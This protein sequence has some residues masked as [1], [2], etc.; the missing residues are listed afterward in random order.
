MRQ[1]I[2]AALAIAEDDVALVA[3]ERLEE[4]DD[5]LRRLL[6]IG[7]HHRE[8]VAAGDRRIPVRIAAKE[9]KLRLKD[10]PCS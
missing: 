5:E 9:P 6:Q 8:I 3:L 1:R 10:A 2:V 7:R 4:L